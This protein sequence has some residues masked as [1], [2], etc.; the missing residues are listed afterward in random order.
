MSEWRDAF[1]KLLRDKGL[2]TRHYDPLSYKRMSKIAND[3]H[4]EL[5]M[6][7]PGNFKDWKDVTLIELANTYAAVNPGTRILERE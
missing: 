1:F 4:A 5:S 3:L 2:F 6:L 7:D